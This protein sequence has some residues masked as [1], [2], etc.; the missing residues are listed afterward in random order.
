MKIQTT[1]GFV[2]EVN[3]NKAKDWRFTKYL[4][5]CEAETGT[6]QGLPLLVNFLLGESGEEALM[7]HV[8]EKNGEI[9]TERILAETKEILN[10]K[11]EQI[12]KSQPSQ[13]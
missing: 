5:M 8:T 1:S 3:E 4:A 6:I 9:P 7:E 12:K 10:L 11:S 13:E 2:C